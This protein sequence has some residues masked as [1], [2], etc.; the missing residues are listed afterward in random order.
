[1]TNQKIE[2]QSF[3]T[4]IKDGLPICL[5]YLSVS[6]AFGIFATEAGLT[7]LEALFISMFNVTSAGQLATVPII[8]VGGSYIELA[9]SQLVIN[10]RYAL[11]SVSLSQKMGE[12]VRVRDRFLIAFVNTDEV[13]AVASSQRGTVGRTYLFGLILLPYLGWSLGTLLGAI[14][15][16]VLPAIVIA[17]LGIAIYGMFIAIVVPFAKDSAQGFFCVLLSAL[18]SCVFY[19]VPAL[20]VI[21]SGFVIIIIALFVSILFALLFP[22]DDKEESEHE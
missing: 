17:A 9:L 10:S 3:K 20:S 6:F 18:L 12:S 7:I 2:N 5:G 15:G 8:A 11:M 4:G 1:M 19:Y 13:F 21:P 22:I 14:A 16:N